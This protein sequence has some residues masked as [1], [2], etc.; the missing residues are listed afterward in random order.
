MTS[1]NTWAIPSL[2]EALELLAS[3]PE[4]QIDWLV[5]VEPHTNVSDEEVRADDLWNC[6]ELALNREDYLVRL[7]GLIEDG[8]VP[9]TTAARIR[10][11]DRY[12]GDR[13]GHEHPEFWTFGALRLS[14][15]WQE[16]RQ[17]ARLALDGLPPTQPRT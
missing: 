8:L 14:P 13:S 2:R 16:V 17:L 11:V 5:K 3:A 15:E 7:P 9:E 12:L 10:A 6:D 4:T 1:D